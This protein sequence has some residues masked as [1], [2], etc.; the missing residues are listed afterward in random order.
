MSA[1]TP[2]SSLNKVSK[3]QAQHNCNASLLLEL[4]DCGDIIGSLWA[5]LIKLHALLLCAAGILADLSFSKSVMAFHFSLCFMGNVDRKQNLFVISLT[6][7]SLAYFFSEKPECVSFACQGN[8]TASL[9]AGYIWHQHSKDRLGSLEP[10]ETA[11]SLN[12]PNTKYMVLIKLMSHFLYPTSIQ[13]FHSCAVSVR[14][15]G[16]WRGA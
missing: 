15:V 3:D 1:K 16:G 2:K 10:S 5:S 7:P 9:T 11:I 4:S 13:P 8:K 14:R 12:A 6:P